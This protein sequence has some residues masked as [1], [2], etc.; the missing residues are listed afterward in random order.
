M[1]FKDYNY[2]RPDYEK[3]KIEF[4]K[5]IDEFKSVE[6]FEECDEKFTEIKKMRNTVATMYCIAYVRHTIDTNDEFYNE[7][8]K[9]W[10]ENSPLYEELDN[11]YFHLCCF[12][13]RQLWLIHVKLEH[14][15]YLIHL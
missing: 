4:S 7:E 11:K 12:H 1:K 14:I 9:Y 6:T 3:Y 5:L 8:L 2:I 13:V 10:D 15:S